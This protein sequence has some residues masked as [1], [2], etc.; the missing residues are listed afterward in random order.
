M[1]KK[2][3]PKPLCIYCHKVEGTTR[4]HVFPFAW[5]PTSTPPK[6]QRRTVPCCLP[7]NGK[8]QEA[9]EAIALDLVFVCD[10]SLPEIAGVQENILNGLN[11]A[12]ARD[13]LDAGHRTGKGQ[14]ILRTMKWVNPIPGAP[15]RYIQK[16][17]VIRPVSPA[18]EID[19]VALRTV[20]TKFIRGL[21]FIEAK[22]AMESGEQTA[23]DPLLPL[24]LVFKAVT[25]PNSRIRMADQRLKLADFPP[26]VLQEL[27][28]TPRITM[29]GPG[30]WYHR[31]R[32]PS[33]SM[34]LFRLW[35][36]L[37]IVAFAYVGAVAAEV[38]RRAAARGQFAAPPNSAFA[39]GKPRQVTDD[40]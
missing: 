30:F 10:P 28:K 38:G 35:G 26:N 9:E 33:V 36:Q 12:H 32:T 11:A 23:V 17:G 21:H 7:C 14:K 4:D 27:L 37:E 25:L 39:P 18:R 1:P 34:W 8:L 20:A 16:N 15:V 5:Y 19:H 40:Q 29:F 3:K 22:A 6:I 13:D 24:D 31:L 2:Q